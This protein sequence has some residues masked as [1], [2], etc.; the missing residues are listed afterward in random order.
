[1]ADIK[2]T[3]PKF[4]EFRIRPAANGFVSERFEKNGAGDFGGTPVR[5]IHP[6]R[7]HL[8]KHMANLFKPPQE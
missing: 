8:L 2:A 7:D 5:N 1:M 4:A 6:D 3:P